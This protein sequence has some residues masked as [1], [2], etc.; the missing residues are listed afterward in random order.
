[1]KEYRWWTVDE[2]AVWADEFAPRQLAAHLGTIL[3]GHVPPSPID[4]GI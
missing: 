1:V 3:A 4:V 2:I